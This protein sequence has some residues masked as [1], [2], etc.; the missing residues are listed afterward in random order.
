MRL[1]SNVHFSS[2]SRKIKF[3]TGGIQVVFRGLKILS[4]AEIE[5]KGTL[6]KGL[7][8]YGGK[9][10]LIIEK[11][12]EK[13]RKLLHKK[14]VD[15]FMVLVEENRRYLSGFRAED[16]QL[17]EISGALFISKEKLILATDGRYELQ[18]KD[19]APLYDVY[20][21]KKGLIHEI[22]D[23]LKKV[24]SKK[25]GF[26]SDRL[27]YHK[28]KKIIEKL[29]KANLKIK[30]IPINNY[31]EDF[32]MIKEDPEI[33]K[34]KQ[35]LKIAEIAFKDMLNNINIQGMTEKEVAWELEKKMI[36]NGAE[37]PSFPTIVASGKNSAMPHATPTSKKININE[38]IIFDWGAKLDGY[39]S[40]ISRTVYIGKKDSFYNKVFNT[41]YDAQKK[42][43]EAI[44][45]GISSKAIDNI[46]RKYID[47]NGFKDKFMHGLGH[48]I[49]LMVH[50]KP[51][52]GRMKDTILEPGM[53]FTVEPGIYI[54]DWGG[55]RLENIVAVHDDG[56]K[57]LNKLELRIEEYN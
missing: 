8:L 23:I 30:F 5:L 10:M 13:L 7:S 52:I 40:D 18:A 29:S 35:S 15:C 20:C 2:S 25:I 28:Y 24:N 53:V 39:C 6:E 54:E 12:I 32:R 47:D 31:I 48:G 9:T 38:P 45:P 22:P 33:K 57:V 21:Y 1:F 55:V 51:S 50:E 42:A 37:S 34:I 56:V 19:E 41:V 36:E 17:D 3:L 43:I 46:S 44:K 16:T 14:K 4:D 27:S 11:R 49:G 26:E